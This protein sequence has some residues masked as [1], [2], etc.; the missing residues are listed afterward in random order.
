MPRLGTQVDRWI[1]IKQSKTQEAITI[2][3]EG[4]FISLKC[5]RIK[6]I[7]M[8]RLGTQV[9]RWIK[10][11]ESKSLEAITIQMPR[12]GTLNVSSIH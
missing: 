1:K 12:L 6:T 9:D 3:T 8:P 2:H 11:K 7:Q 5:S 4:L 10:I